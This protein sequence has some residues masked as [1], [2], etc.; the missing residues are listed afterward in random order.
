MLSKV[1]SYQGKKS[2]NQSRVSKVAIA[3]GGMV[4]MCV[5]F[6]PT[7]VLIAVGMFNCIQGGIEPTDTFLRVDL[8]IPCDQKHAA[9]KASV[10]VWLWAIVCMFVPGLYLLLLRESHTLE[11]KATLTKFGYLYKGYRDDMYMWYVRAKIL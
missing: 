1:H 6:F 2:G 7:L 10:G 3:I 9:M 8:R 5:I 4:F 11:S